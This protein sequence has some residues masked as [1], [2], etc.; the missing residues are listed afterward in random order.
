MVSQARAKHE[1]RFS[2]KM[3]YIWRFMTIG[4]GQRAAC[5]V[6]SLLFTLH[7]MHWLV[8]AT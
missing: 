4:A 8:T 3:L 1:A 5:L 7:S 6:S 2:Q